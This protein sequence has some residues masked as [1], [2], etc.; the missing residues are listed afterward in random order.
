[1]D[2]MPIFN[3]TLGI[4]IPHPNISSVYG[5][6]ES[7]HAFYVIQP[8]VQYTLCDTVMFSPYKLSC[9]H[10]KQLFIVYQI[11]QATK[12]CHSLG[13]SVGDL[14]LCDLF[15][16]EKL[17]MHLNVP[18]LR[19]IYRS[20]AEPQKED[21][22]PIS[23]EIKAVSSQVVSSQA[24]IQCSNFQNY[25]SE[26][27]PVLVQKWTEGQICNF[28]YL[29][30]LNHLAKRDMCDPNHH[31]VLPWV[32]DFN[33]P[34]EMGGYRD[35]NKSK[36]R[37][38]KG[39]RQL[40]LTYN[41]TDPEALNDPLHIPHHVS[42]VLSDITYYVYK[43]RRTSKQLLC[44]HVRS[45]WVPHEYP[46]TMQRLQ[47]WTPDECIPE[48]FT[49]PTIFESI[50]KDLPD[51]GIPSWAASPEEFVRKH[52]AVLEGDHVSARL[53]QWIDL[54]F[55]FKVSLVHLKTIK[56]RFYCHVNMFYCYICDTIIQSSSKRHINE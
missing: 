24:Q 23:N 9:S 53:H 38:N 3:P 1:M 25:L 56:L 41:I 2:E 28:D 18:S 47:E 16:D 17:W 40:D 11:L 20:V 22:P 5:I 33:S 49:D 44:T 27:L 35:L 45:K 46:S 21:N 36:Y 14:R 43:A 39:D 8:F 19:N 52:M 6:L 7:K 54:T 15:I 48:F 13:I 32:T 37:L 31:P 29:M 42:E 55:G 34:T 4:N 30:I 50:H 51:L 12:Y 26:D 10:T